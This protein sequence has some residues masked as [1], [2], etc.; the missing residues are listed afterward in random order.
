MCTQTVPADPAAWEDAY[1]RFAT[2]QQE[3]RKFVRRLQALGAHQWDRDL[4]VAE[5][6]CG[7][8]NGVEAWR[9]LG[10]ERVE[11]L[12]LS[13]ELVRQYRGSARIRVGD[14][15]ALPFEDASRDVVCVQGGLHHLNG[16]EDVRRV[17]QEIR[18][19]LKTGGRLV[20]I[21]PWL[22]PFLRFVHA[23]CRLRFLR[24]IS[25]RL[26]ALATMIELERATYDAWLD[27]PQAI[28][29]ALRAV[30]EP[31]FLRIGSGKLMLVGRA[32]RRVGLEHQ[33]QKPLITGRALTP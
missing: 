18:R 10:F 29:E 24:R 11:G 14:A 5:L 28:L 12:D 2:P 3:T 25:P 8:G 30:A 19:V 31:A 4:R 6:F 17:L 1:L 15:R 22:T 32:R 9:Q 33:C 21:E 27:A 20:V 7:R 13:A 16:M 26:D 23:A